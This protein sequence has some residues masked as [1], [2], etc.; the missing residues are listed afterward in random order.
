MLCYILPFLKI[1]IDPCLYHISKWALKHGLNPMMAEK[2]TSQLS[3]LLNPFTGIQLSMGNGKTFSVADVMALYVDPIWIQGIVCIAVLGSIVGSGLYLKRIV[4][5]KKVVSCLCAR[6]I[7]VLVKDLHPH[8][9]S[10]MRRKQITVAL[11]EDVSSPCIVGKAIL[12]PVRLFQELSGKEKEAIIVHE[13]AHFQWRDGSLRM[14]CSFVACVFWWIPTKGALKR[15]EDAQEEAADAAIHPFG[16]MGAILA[17]AMVKTVREA[18]VI[19]SRFAF[20]FVAGPSQTSQRIKR[21]LTASPR[22]QRWRVVPYGLMA[23][24]WLSIMFGTL[25]I[26]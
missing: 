17:S 21:L 1:C 22:F 3:V 5:E 2:G 14:V 10:W 6:A 23:C 11:S 7:P 15:M 25:W 8:L 19:K 26:F 18:K 20:S 24:A 9:L 16:I 13:G 12:F 4:G